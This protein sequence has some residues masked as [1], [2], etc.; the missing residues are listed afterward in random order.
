MLN[1]SEFC[2]GQGGRAVDRDLGRP[3]RAVS[4]GRAPGRPGRH[5]LRVGCRCRTRR[6]QGLSSSCD[7][8]GRTVFVHEPA[9]V[10][11]SVAG[12]APTPDG[13]A[14]HG[15]RGPRASVVY[16]GPVEVTARGAKAESSV[17]GRPA[18]VRAPRTTAKVRRVGA[19]RSITL[20]AS[21]ASGVCGDHRPGRQGT[22]A[23]VHAGPEGRPPRDRPLL[24]R[25]HVRQR[26]AQAP[27]QALSGGSMRGADRSA[28][29]VRAAP[30]QPGS[31][32]R[33][34]M[35]RGRGRGRREERCPRSRGPARI[36]GFR[37]SAGGRR[38]RSRPAAATPRPAT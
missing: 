1:A 33:S 17:A 20:K 13:D 26:R 21:D 16:D 2:D 11:R 38:R 31:T 3:P 24:V 30:S 22:A 19:R 14:A 34:W 27:G 10:D 6:R 32:D 29:A 15:R 4:A 36:G 12:G 35:T 18:D 37:L 5:R 28:R 9:N 7:D 25:R 23:S 8:G